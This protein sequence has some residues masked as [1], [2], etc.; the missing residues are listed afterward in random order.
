MG[1]QWHPEWLEK[2]VRN[3][4][5]WFVMRLIASRTAKQLHTRILTLDTHCDTPMFFPQGVD[6]A[7][8]DPRILYDLHKMTEGHQDAVTMAAYLPQP[9]IGETFSSKIDVEGLKRFNPEL[10]DV[11]NN[12]T[13]TS[14]ADLIFNKIEKIVKDN[15]RY[16]SIARTPSDLYEDKRKGRKSIM[17]A[18]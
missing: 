17:F 5:K 18:N 12:L 10:T 2:M 13:P 7:K 1:V 8:R 4:L 11:L 16:L 6:F 9:R 3:Y 14:Y 15:N